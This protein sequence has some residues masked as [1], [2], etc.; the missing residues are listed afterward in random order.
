MTNKNVESVP[1]DVVLEAK[2]HTPIWTIDAGK[3]LSS[4]H[5][6]SH[7]GEFTS[8]IDVGSGTG[9]LSQ[10]IAQL[11]Y[12]DEV[13]GIEP[14]IQSV[15]VTHPKIKLEKM[16]F[17]EYCTHYSPLPV[18]QCNIMAFLH[19][20]HQMTDEELYD[21]IRSTMPNAVVILDPNPE[22]VAKENGK[23]F[24]PHAIRYRDVV[25]FKLNLLNFGYNLQYSSK[26]YWFEHDYLREIAVF[27]LDK[28]AK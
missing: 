17:S 3:M 9:A 20:A 11:P 6:L 27:L 22:W 21:G 15:L 1:Y 8:V 26:Y 2:T 25:D 10:L 19:S 24:D 23:I 4:I 18:N 12:V 13:I 7:E 28:S 5:D 14:Y 16:S